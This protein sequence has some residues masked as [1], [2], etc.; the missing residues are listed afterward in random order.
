MIHRTGISTQMIPF[1]IL[2]FGSTL[3]QCMF[4]DILTSIQRWFS[5]V[6]LKLSA[7]KSEYTIIRKCKIIK[8]DFLRLQEDGDYTEQV[9]VLGCYIDCQLTL[10]IQ[11]NFVSSNSFYYL[12][13][14]WSIHDQVKTSVLIELIRVLVLSLI[15]YCISL[16][17]GLPKFLLEKKSANNELCR[18]FDF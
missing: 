16:Y 2:Y 1:F 5:N 8:H 17:Y 10:Q 13:K 7:D 12:R 4:D 15:D 3:S 14:V 6:K 9:K 11:V 18:A